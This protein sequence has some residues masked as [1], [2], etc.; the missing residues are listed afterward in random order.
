VLALQPTGAV[1]THAEI[2]RFA[3]WAQ[4]KK[5][6][7]IAD[8]IYRRITTARARAVVPRPPDDLLERVCSSPGV[9]KT[10]AMTGWR[11][12]FAPRRPRSRKRWRRCS[13]HTTRAQI[14]RP[15]NTPPPPP[16]ATTGRQD[17]NRMVG[18]FRKRR[19][20]VS[21]LPAD[22]P[23][24][25]IRRPP[26]RVLL[27]LRVDS[28]GKIIRHGL[29]HTTD[30]AERWWRSRGCALEMIAGEVVVCRCNR[31]DQAS[32]DRIVTFVRKLGTEASPAGATDFDATRVI[33]Q[34]SSIL[35]PKLPELVN[36]R[37]SVNHDPGSSR[38]AFL[39]PCTAARAV[40]SHAVAQPVREVLAI[41]HRG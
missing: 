12:G 22:L 37:S 15:P 26:R 40:H 11:I 24:C 20:L 1:Y 7:V 4:A 28:F 6:W 8:E 29:L 34:S 38:V 27:F 9:S 17:V 30:H 39:P 16:S 31:F 23:R 25:G 5:V 21:P 18:E 13:R 14:T 33:I 10:Y 36:P 41:P 32:L 3:Q 19:D 2:A 35:T